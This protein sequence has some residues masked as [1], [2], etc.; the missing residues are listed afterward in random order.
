MILKVALS[1]LA[2]SSTIVGL[3]PP[4][5]KIHLVRF[6]EAALATNLPLAGLP[7]KTITSKG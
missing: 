2:S 6:S 4:N 1:I 7:V 3:L 5:S